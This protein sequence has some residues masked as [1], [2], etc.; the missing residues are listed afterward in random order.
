MYTNK[1]VGSKSFMCFLYGAP[2]SSNQ[3]LNTVDT[4]Q[5]VKPDRFHNNMKLQYCLWPL[6]LYP[7]GF[8]PSTFSLRE[9]NEYM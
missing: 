5:F 2:M 9:W 8:S 7:Y 3:L 1:T 4:G 6:I